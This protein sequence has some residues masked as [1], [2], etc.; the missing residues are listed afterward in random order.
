MQTFS[1]RQTVS[2]GSSIEKQAC[3]STAPPAVQQPQQSVVT[4]EIGSDAI[5]MG[6]SICLGSE[7]STERS[8]DAKRPTGRCCAS[9]QAQTH[10]VRA[11]LSC[12]SLV[13]T[14]A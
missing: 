10:T 13:G 3:K 8:G 11:R 6:Q 5:S 4:A 7:L 14:G 12:C 2:G 1:Q 9:R